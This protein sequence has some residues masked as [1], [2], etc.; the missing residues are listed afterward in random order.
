MKK[1]TNNIQVGAPRLLATTSVV[2]GP[3]QMTIN[4]VC[5]ITS[6]VLKQKFPSLSVSFDELLAFHES[7]LKAA[8]ARAIDPD[9]KLD[10]RLVVPAY[11]D[12]LT[13]GLQC[14]IGRTIINPVLCPSVDITLPTC[15]EEVKLQL[16]ALNVPCLRPRRPLTVRTNTLLCDVVTVDGILTIVGNLGDMAIDDMVRRTLIEVEAESLTLLRSL[17]GE[18]AFQYGEVDQLLVNYFA[19][20]VRA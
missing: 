3:S 10:R 8:I 13:E 19:A 5:K 16:M 20:A 9:C 4:D 1:D 18:L 12:V 6:T 2:A 11:Y 15:Y 14:Q 7:S 17:M